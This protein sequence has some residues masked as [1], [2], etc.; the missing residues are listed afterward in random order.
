VK[1]PP[2]LHTDHTRR[3]LPVAAWPTVRHNAIEVIRHHRRA[4]TGVLLWHGGAALTAL[5]APWV[6]G[7]LVDEITGARRVEE[8]NRLLIVLAIGILAEAVLTWFARRAAFVLAETIFAKVREDFVASTVRLPLS[9][10][11]RAGTGDLVARTTGDVDALS[12]VVR[13]GIPS[14]LVAGTSIVAIVMAA[15][16]TAPLAVLGF[17]VAPLLLWQPVRVYLR[18]ALPGYRWERATYAGLAG[19]A[20]ETVHG[21]TTMDALGRSGRRRD[22]HRSALARA[23]AAEHWT[24]RFRLRF[25]PWVDVAFGSLVAVTALWAGWLS[26]E[27]VLTVGAAV[28]VTLYAQRLIDPIGEVVGW[29]D[30]IQVAAT[31]YARLLGVSEVPEDR[32]PSGAQPTGSALSVQGVGYAYRPGHHVLHDVTLDLRPGERL[33]IVGPSGAGKST[34]GRLMAG[35][36]APHTGRIAV[37]GVP[38]V[39]LDLPTLRGEVALVTQEHHVFVGTL[40]DNLRLPRPD[41][42]DAALR[43]ALRAVDA[44]GWALAL[45]DG[46]ETVVGSGG[47]GLTEAQAQQLSL[48]RLVL[49]DPHTLVLD[50]ATSLL[51]PRAAR[52]LERSLAAVVAGRTVVA[53]AHR[54]HTAHDADRVCVMADGRIEELGSHGELL[55]ADGSYAALWRT[56]HGG[57]AQPKG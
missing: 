42:S 46:L 31:G 57:S 13:Q 38:L 50:E 11:E 39:D 5:A 32:S 14:L 36:D 47:H 49:A 37:G 53:I 18:R 22:A 52:H 28:A 33:A 2:E 44:D 15:L 23:E 41:A 48:A 34:L 56:W 19:V 25:F 27:G 24:L 8:V 10:V 9:V 7:H 35:V 30:E 54:L 45:P 12:H 1:Q 51:D 6:V 55:A 20:A 3:R 43:A 4:L 26:L 17:V 40:A 29:L 21:L 16:F